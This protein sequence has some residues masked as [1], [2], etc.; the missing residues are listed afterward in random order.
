MK[1]PIGTVLILAAFILMLSLPLAGQVLAQESP[2]LDVT[3]RNVTAGQ[4]LTPPV[5]IVHNGSLMTLPEDPEA[6]AG[7]GVLA[8]SG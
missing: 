1:R 5:V 7:F 8:E 2:S 3:V 4:P 6:I